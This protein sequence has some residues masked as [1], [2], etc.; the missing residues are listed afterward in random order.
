VIINQTF[1]TKAL[2]FSSFAGLIKQRVK[3]KECKKRINIRFSFLRVYIS[4][5]SII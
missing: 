3:K 4:E 2:L 5:F 1:V